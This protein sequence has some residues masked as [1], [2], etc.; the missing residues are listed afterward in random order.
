MKNLIIQVIND[1]LYEFK[2]IKEYYFYENQ[3]RT[4]MVVI[5]NNDQATVL[6]M[7]MIVFYSLEEKNSMLLFSKKDKTDE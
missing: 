4:Y 1:Q 7:D 5:E 6:N 2:N 3:D